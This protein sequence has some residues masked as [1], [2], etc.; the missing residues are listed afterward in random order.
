MIALITDFAARRSQQML[1]ATVIACGL[2]IYYSLPDAWL[3]P[4]RLTTMAAAQW[5]VG[6]ALQRESHHG[7]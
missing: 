3:F 5:A 4:V 2:L 1:I 7:L 6:W